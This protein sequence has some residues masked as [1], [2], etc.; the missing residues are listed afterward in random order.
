M[1][2]ADSRPLRK[3]EAAPEPFRQFRSWFEQAQSAGL[4][5]PDAMTLATVSL[6]GK[7]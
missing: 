4:L 1:A 3:A 6:E 7:P 5:R 2:N